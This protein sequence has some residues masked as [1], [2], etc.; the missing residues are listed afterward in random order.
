MFVYN[1]TNKNEQKLFETMY[2]DYIYELSLYSERLRMN[3]VTEKEIYNINTNPL[4]ERYFI[5]DEN[6]AP[7][8]FCLLGFGKNTAPGTDWHIADFYVLPS[9]RRRKYAEAAMAE[10]L[11]VHPG[12]YCC[13]VL[14]ENFPAQNF[15]NTIVQTFDCADITTECDIPPET[16][17]D[18]IFRVFET[19]E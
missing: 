2:L 18:C 13:F 1:S 7:V 6:G 9:H 12:K 15:W 11:Q 10:L 19:A 8:G 4:L 14:K 3:P 16:P 17:S 5:T